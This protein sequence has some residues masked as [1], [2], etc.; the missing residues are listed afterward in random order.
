[1]PSPSSPSCITGGSPEDMPPV[2]VGG[3]QGQGAGQR[4]P[5]PLGPWCLVGLSLEWALAV[6][7]PDGRGQSRAED[8]GC[9][10]GKRFSGGSRA[11]SHGLGPLGGLKTFFPWK[12]AAGSC[13]AGSAWAPSHRLRGPWPWL[14]SGWFSSPDFPRPGWGWS[15]RQ[16]SDSWV[17]GWVSLQ[18]VPAL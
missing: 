16:G 10:S 15:V 3:P 12:V 13:L 5:G 7:G 18:Q 9:L 1:M 14:S 6:T 17:L 4:A 2:L 11:L 8:G